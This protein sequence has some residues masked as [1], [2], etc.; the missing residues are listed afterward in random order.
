MSPHRPPVIRDGDAIEFGITPEN[1]FRIPYTFAEALNEGTLADRQPG[2][3][4]RAAQEQRLFQ[5]VNAANENMIATAMIQDYARGADGSHHEGQFGALIV[6]PAARGFGIA[7]LLIKIVMV[8]EFG[9]NRYDAGEEEYVAHVMDG[10]KGPIHALVHA[11]FRPEG[12][13]HIH[14]DDFSGAMGHMVE[15][16]DTDI[17]MHRYVFDPAAIDNLI[18]D[19]WKF[20][21]E[22]GGIIENHHDGAR[23]RADFAD[24]I[25]PAYI[26][27]HIDHLKEQDRLPNR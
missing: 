6:H 22:D 20:Q 12:Y 14:L 3:F 2:S 8:H 17:V 27:A 5:V 15:E 1:E 23:V 25:D 21:T 24:A 19:L 4:K 26:E 13:L 7:S 9:A 11:G 10:N 16:G 18:Y